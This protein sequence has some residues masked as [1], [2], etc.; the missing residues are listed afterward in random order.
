[1]YN[2]ILGRQFL[3]LTASD[4]IINSFSNDS[5]LVGYQFCVTTIPPSIFPKFLKL[6]L[7]KN[8]SIATVGYI[9]CHC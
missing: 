5:L 6:K 4:K 8:F 2:C 1:M 3:L 9:M 7:V